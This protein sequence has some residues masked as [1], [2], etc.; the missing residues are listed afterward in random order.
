MILTLLLV[1]AGLWAVSRAAAVLIEATLRL[2]RRRCALE[3]AARKG[4]E[5]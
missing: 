2:E 4:P 5:R 1:R 3:Q